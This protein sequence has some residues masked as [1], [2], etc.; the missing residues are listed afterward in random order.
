MADRGIFVDIA[1]IF[2]EDLVEGFVVKGAED[3]TVDVFRDVVP[4]LL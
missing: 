1:K 3:F 2:K 4:N